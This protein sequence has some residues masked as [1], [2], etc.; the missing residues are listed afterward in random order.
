MCDLYARRQPVFNNSYPVFVLGATS[1]L[2]FCK[3]LVRVLAG[4]FSAGGRVT[5]AKC[6]RLITTSVS[7]QARAVRKSELIHHAEGPPHC[8]LTSYYLGIVCR[9]TI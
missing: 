1:T 2:T 3:M 7:L 6:C 8:T 5:Q 4:R 9:K